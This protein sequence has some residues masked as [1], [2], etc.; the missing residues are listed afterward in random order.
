[1]KTVADRHIRA[2]YRNKH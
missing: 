1:M 2:A